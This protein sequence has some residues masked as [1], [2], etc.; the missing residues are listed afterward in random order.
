MLV[1]TLEC[2]LEQATK[3]S[4]CN[5]HHAVDCVWLDLTVVNGYKC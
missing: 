1:F 4:I 5:L 3:E 2:V